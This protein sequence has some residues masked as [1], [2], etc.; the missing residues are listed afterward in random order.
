MATRDE[1]NINRIKEEIRENYR[2]EECWNNLLNLIEQKTIVQSRDLYDSLIK[3]FPTSLKYWELYI[4]YEIERRNFV[5]LEKLFSKCLP[6]YP[7]VKLWQMYLNYLKLLKLSG[8]GE[9]ESSNEESID[10]MK[11]MNGKLRKAY[12]TAINNIGLS[13][14]SSMI[15]MDYINLLKNDPNNSVLLPSTST[16]SSSNTTSVETL[17]NCRRLYQRLF[18]LPIDSL[19]NMWRDFTQFENNHDKRSAR[20]FI[21]ERSTSYQNLSSNIIPKISLY[22]QLISRSTI[23]SALPPFCPLASYLNSVIRSRTPG[24]KF[25]DELKRTYRLDELK[26]NEKRNCNRLIEEEVTHKRCWKAY[27]DW[28]KTN[29]LK[30]DETQFIERILFFYDQALLTLAYHTDIWYESITFLLERLHNICK[31]NKN[32][33]NIDETSISN[34]ILLRLERAVNTF[35]CYDPLFNLIYAN[36]HELNGNIDKANDIYQSYIN[37]VLWYNDQRYEQKN[38]LNMNKNELKRMKMSNNYNEDMSS[39][40]FNE[41]LSITFIEYAPLTNAIPLT[42]FYIQYINFS[43]RNY[44]ME[45]ARNVFTHARRTYTT[46]ERENRNTKGNDKLIGH[47]LFIYFLQF[48]QCHHR[49]NEKKKNKKSSDILMETILLNFQTNAKCLKK[50]FDLFDGEHHEMMSM[51]ETLHQCINSSFNKIEIFQLWERLSYYQMIHC[52]PI[53]IINLSNGKYSKEALHFVHLASSKIDNIDTDNNDEEIIPMLEDV[54][55]MRYTFDDLLPSSLTNLFSVDFFRKLINRDRILERSEENLKKSFIHLI[56]QYSLLT[57]NMELSEDSD[58]E[59]LS[60]TYLMNVINSHCNKE[61]SKG[62][63]SE[64]NFSVNQFLLDDIWIKQST[65]FPQSLKSLRGCQLTRFDVQLFDQLLSRKS[66]IFMNTNSSNKPK[67]NIESFNQSTSQLILP[68][69]KQM[70][71]YRPMYKD[72]LND[73]LIPDFGVPTPTCINVL[74]NRLPHPRCFI[75]PFVIIEKLLKILEQIDFPILKLNDDDIEM[76]MGG[77]SNDDSMLGNK[78]DLSKVNKMDVFHSRQKQLANN[79]N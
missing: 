23:R 45:Q 16:P 36:Y 73:F 33:K 28:E 48:Q 5:C 34:E 41:L 65:D 50:C 70:L 27:L 38:R 14:N 49:Q 64:I 60:S 43:Q 19:E 39:I 63:K 79:N 62:N 13:Y 20:R 76:T 15:W 21:D 31:L 59:T 74:I 54:I 58:L 52:F 53:N 18:Q 71:P 46:Y 75:G 17:S 12:E 68:D 47:Q 9:E 69:L 25:D 22:Q 40:N 6:L 8:N 66:T 4:Q 37:R 11:E 26:E 1:R 30:L 42:S 3:I 67:E 7:H 10:E 51:F 55:L 2:D 61:E 24:N 77:R 29:P 56:K 72:E 57:N 44:G 78:I 35:M 32:E